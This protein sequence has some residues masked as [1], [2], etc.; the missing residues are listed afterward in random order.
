MSRIL[1]PSFIETH[2]ELGGGKKGKKES[3]LREG[4]RHDTPTPLPPDQSS[5]K[6]DTDPGEG[7]LGQRVVVL[8]T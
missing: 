7:E 8:V 2:N 4:G 5:L 6:H 3:K 1:T